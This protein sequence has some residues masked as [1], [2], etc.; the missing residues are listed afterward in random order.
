MDKKIPPMLRCRGGHLF[1]RTI[2]PREYFTSV[3]ILFFSMHNRSDPQGYELFPFLYKTLELL[4]AD[5]SD[6]LQQR[7]CHEGEDS[8]PNQVGYKMKGVDRVYFSLFAGLLQLSE[9][10]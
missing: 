1:K 5:A 6:P 9:H 7:S 3:H 4:I 10:M 8:Q 2:D